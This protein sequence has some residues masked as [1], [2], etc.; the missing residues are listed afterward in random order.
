MV[1]CLAEQVHGYLGLL[2]LLTYLLI[3]A[4]TLLNHFTPASYLAASLAWNNSLA[5]LLL[6]LLAIAGHFSLLAVYGFH[7]CPPDYTQTSIM[8]LAASVF[9]LIIMVQLSIILDN[10]VQQKG[11]WRC[12]SSCTNDT[13]LTLLY[14]QLVPHRFHEKNKDE[15]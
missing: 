7:L 2:E 12:F 6:V 8:V 5:G 4:A 9:G 10:W 1:R 11:V 3:T 13:C 14:F 15:T